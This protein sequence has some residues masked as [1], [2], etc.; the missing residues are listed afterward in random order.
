[1][2]K[3]NYLIPSS[4]SHYLF[5]LR[6]RPVFLKRQWNGRGK[7]HHNKLSSFSISSLLSEGY[8]TLSHPIFCDTSVCRLMQ[9]LVSMN[10]ME[11]VSVL[12]ACKGPV[13]IITVSHTGCGERSLLTQQASKGLVMKQNI[14][15]MNNYSGTPTLMV[16]NRKY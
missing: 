11:R 8:S 10:M 6:L 2:S 1:M 3:S 15:K 5:Y 4:V 7:L 16:I 9:H 14:L 13:R 12:E